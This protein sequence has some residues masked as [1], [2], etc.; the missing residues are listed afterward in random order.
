[1]SDGAAER[2]R[3]AE[4]RGLRRGEARGGKKPRKPKLDVPS[5]AAFEPEEMSRRFP[6][7]RAAGGTDA[8]PVSASALMPER[9]AGGGLS[10]RFTGDVFGCGPEEKGGFISGGVNFANAAD[11]W[12]G[13]SAVGVSEGGIGV[14]KRDARGYM[15]EGAGD[16]L[17]RKPQSGMSPAATAGA[18]RA[19][20]AFT[21]GGAR[22]AAASPATAF[23]AAT[24]GRLTGG[25]TTDDAHALSPCSAAQCDENHAAAG[26]SSPAA[27][28]RYAPRREKTL[29]LYFHIP[30]CR[31]KCAYCD[32]YSRPAPEAAQ[33]DYVEALE[34][35][36]EKLLPLVEGYAVESVYVGGGTPSM[37]P[38]PLFAR[39]LATA[40]RFA[41][42]EN[43]EITAE[44]NPAPL[45]PELF[46]QWRRAGVNRLSLGMQ[47]ALDAELRAV[48]RRHGFT[49]V[50]AAVSAARAAG[51]ENVSLDLMLGLPGQTIKSALFSLDRA[52]SLWPEHMSVYCLKLEDGTPLARRAARGRVELP[53]DDLVAE[54]YLACCERLAAEGLRQYEISNFAREGFRSRHNLRY[55]RLGEYLGVGAAA[56]SFFGG[57]R[58]FFPPD[59]AAF[60]ALAAGEDIGW[61]DDEPSDAAEEALILSLRTADGYSSAEMERLAG[62]RAAREI[63]KKLGRFAESGHA[64][65]TPSGFALTPK[66]MLVSN[67]I[68]SDLLLCLEQYGE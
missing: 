13:R 47:S 49:D 67:A 56:H 34:A 60:A 3:G 35:A 53:D 1:M 38:A 59:A 2:K 24:D 4:K 42:S 33:A 28:S 23:A 19:A 8:A 15:R 29:G 31:S 11:E 41:V 45:P 25:G 6:T 14:E 40:K 43:A 27:E 63:G 65:Q 39:V 66:G 58:R 62:A 61:T 21:M 20:R 22:Y 64:L 48:G 26:D 17:L 7:G 12:G 55:W 5:A 51:I 57:R 50:A 37:L 18:E 30:F 44:A 46:S 10:N 52:L 32:F 9:S 54:M 16:D 36:A 68:L